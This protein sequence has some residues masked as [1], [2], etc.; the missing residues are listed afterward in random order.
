MLFYV[1][2][3]PKFAPIDI[4]I[5]SEPANVPTTTILLMF[6]SLLCEE[7]K[8]SNFIVC[9]YVDHVTLRGGGA[10]QGTGCFALP[11]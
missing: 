2:A 11:C 8:S 9:Q 1:V 7:K 10:R 5:T 3:P 4:T 6:E